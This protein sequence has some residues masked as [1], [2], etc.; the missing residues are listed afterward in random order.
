MELLSTY[1]L[2]FL[3]YSMFGWIYETILCSIRQKKFI[4]RGFLNGPYCPIYGVGA[5]INIIA[6]GKVENPIYIFLLGTIFNLSLEYFTSWGME[7]IFH[8]RW[9]DYSKRK[10]N[11]KGR[12]CLLGAVVFG[13][14]SV[15]L[16]KGLHPIVSSYTSLIPELILNILS[17]ILFV[18]ILLDTTYTVTKF[19]QLER[20]LKELTEY[21]N[22]LIS[23]DYD[24]RKLIIEKIKDTEIFEE[25]SF[26][27][28]N[29]FKKINFQERRILKAF[30]KFKSL[31]YNMALQKIKEFINRKENNK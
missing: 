22:N 29:I 30:P 19:A 17:P 7:K 24:Y 27:Y 1:F 28:Q 31:R 12:I 21:M 3:I 25:T 8:A 9:W 2:W 5:V 18:I 4:N 23:K 13:T 16:I 10:F 26:I 20:K 6:L 15:L 11:I 14:F